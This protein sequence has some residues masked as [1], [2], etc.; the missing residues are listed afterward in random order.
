MCVI[1][2]LNCLQCVSVSNL[3]AVWTGLTRAAEQLPSQQVS[4]I[5]QE[6]QVEVPEKLHVF[7]LHAELL[8]RVPVD[9]LKPHQE[10][11]SVQLKRPATLLEYLSLHYLY[12]TAVNSDF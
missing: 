3:D 5:L 8:R 12:S 2:Q 1:C 4:V 7:V 10:G 6:G 11:N 9:H